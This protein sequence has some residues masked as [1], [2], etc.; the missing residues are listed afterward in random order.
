MNLW[1]GLELGLGLGLI[2][3]AFLDFLFTTI[4]ANTFHFLSHRIA[5]GM[6]RL[7][8]H[9]PRWRWTYSAVGPLTMSAVACWWI[10][11]LAGG[12]SLVFAAFDPGI[13]DI[14]TGST[15][16]FWGALAHSGHLLSTLGGSITEPAGVPMALVGSFAAVTGMVVLTLSVSFVL[17]TTQTVQAGRALLTLATAIPPGNEHFATTFLP[18]LANLV[19]RL[20]AAPFA[21]F[22]SHVDPDMRLPEGIARL[23]GQAQGETREAMGEILSHLVLSDGIDDPSDTLSWVRRYALDR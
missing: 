4:G 13:V 6:F 11:G 8:K 22:Y 12:W 20:N 9:L 21:L 1:N 10:T 15:V 2:A 3:Y 5:R 16:G 19:A 23:H 14:D 18:Q 7:H 17:S